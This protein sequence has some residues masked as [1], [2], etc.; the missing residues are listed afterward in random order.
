M[1]YPDSQKIQI[2]LSPGQPGSGHPGLMDLPIQKA[3]DSV[4]AAGGGVVIFPAGAYITAGFQLKSNV[5]LQLDKGAILYG[6]V[7]YADYRND[8]FISGTDLS[9]I[10][11]QG[12]GTID[13]VDCFNPRGEEGFR[14]PKC[15]TLT[16]C[17]NI[18]LKNFTIKNSASWA[19][20]CR[21]CSYAT[22]DKLTILGG[23]DGLATRYCNNFEVTRCDFRTGDDSFAGND[24]KDFRISDSKINSACNG[25]R[26]GCYNLTIERCTIWGPAEYPKKI[27][28]RTAME[29][30]FVHYSPKGAKAISGNWLIKNVIISGMDNVYIYNYE[31]GAW[32]NGQP[33]SIVKFENVKATKVR[34]AFT[35]IGDKERQFQLI[36]KNSSFSYSE[37]FPYGGVNYM[38]IDFTSAPFFNISNFGS[39]ELNNVTLEKNSNNT[40]LNCSSGNKI[41]L[42]G[43]TY[44]PKSNSDPFV[45]EN[46]KELIKTK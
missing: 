21:Y 46:I 40:L 14:G 10:T 26:V 24:N 39:L 45:S 30:A 27:S 42:N 43:V 13:G 9:N 23:H 18:T 4:A 19:I 34:T 35:V 28:K 44:L 22:V 38:G 29:A 3:I 16:R 37:G 7:N 6:S 15:I 25:F 33:V 12:E 36:I 1:K 11:I 8:L 20:N 31:N 41:V 2:I 5:T 17:K 32:Q